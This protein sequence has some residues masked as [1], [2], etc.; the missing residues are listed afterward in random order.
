MTSATQRRNRRKSVAG[1]TRSNYP[2]MTTSASGADRPERWCAATLGGA[3]EL[4]VF[5]A[6]D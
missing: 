3:R 5:P 2:S 4:S 6:S 1:L